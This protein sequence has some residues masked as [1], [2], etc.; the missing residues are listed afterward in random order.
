MWDDYWEREMKNSRV[1]FFA[2]KTAASKLEVLV[3]S[4][5]T[6]FRRQEKLLIQVSDDTAARYVDTLLWKNPISGFLPHIVTEEES[7][8]FIVI[9]TATKNLN[10]A[11]YVFNLNKT[12]ILLDSYQLVY[13]FEDISSISRL[14]L[15]K[16]R[17]EVYNSRNYFIEAG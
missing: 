11:K 7:Q 15:S 14:Q 6:H 17:F 3:K 9:T 4:A 8:D 13:D 12:P 16:Y 10:Q 1:L 2:V 5:Y